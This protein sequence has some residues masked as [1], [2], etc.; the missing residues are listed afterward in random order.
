[1]HVISHGIRIARGYIV[2]ICTWYL[3]SWGDI[4]H[5]LCMVSANTTWGGVKKANAS[6]DAKV[7]LQL[8]LELELE[9]ANAKVKLEVRVRHF[10]RAGTV[11]CECCRFL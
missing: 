7:K 1:L 8:E 2:C 10:A 4:L 3:H 11:P 9:N 6:A 5:N